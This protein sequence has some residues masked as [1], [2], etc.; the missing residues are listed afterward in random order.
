MTG[1]LLAGRGAP[2][3]AATM[4]QEGSVDHTG[5]LALGAMG[6]LGVGLGAFGFFHRQEWWGAIAFG[7]GSS[8]VGGAG[9]LLIDRLVP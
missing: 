9:V 4:G 5:A 6:L 1:A 2:T 7:A 3:P 8:V